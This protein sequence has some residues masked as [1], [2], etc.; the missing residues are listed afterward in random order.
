[1]RSYIVALGI[2]LSL[3]AIMT[4]KS[5]A[6]VGAAAGGVLL[7]KAAIAENSPIIDI[8]GCVRCSSKSKSKAKK[9]GH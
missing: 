1:M 5:F 8:S 2:A 9:S 6:G 7:T 3:G 4:S